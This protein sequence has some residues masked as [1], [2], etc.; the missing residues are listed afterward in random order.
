MNKEKLDN[1]KYWI[2]LSQLKNESTTKI[3]HFG[4][5]TLSNHKVSIITIWMVYPFIKKK[6]IAWSQLML[7]HICIMLFG[8][9]V[10]KMSGNM[11]YINYL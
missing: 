1:H 5:S 11:I 8:W 10:Q 9:Q 2:T 6:K 7:A 3:I 4:L